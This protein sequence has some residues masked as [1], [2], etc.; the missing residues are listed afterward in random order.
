[1]C[2]LFLAAT[3]ILVSSANITNSPWFVERIISLMY[4]RNK[5]GPS[6]DPCG[7]PKSIVSVS[8]LISLNFVI[9]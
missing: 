1:M 7:T 9:C 2:A 5:R 6:T 4:K 3:N 8:D